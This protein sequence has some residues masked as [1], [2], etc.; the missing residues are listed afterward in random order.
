MSR[1]M[2]CLKLCYFRHRVY[3][4]LVVE[5]VR[6]V[7]SIIIK[8]TIIAA[9]CLKISQPVSATRTPF[10]GMFAGDSKEHDACVVARAG[11]GRTLPTCLV[12]LLRVRT[13]ET[14]QK[15]PCQHIFCPYTSLRTRNPHYTTACFTTTEAIGIHMEGTGM[16]NKIE[17]RLSTSVIA[18]T[19]E[20]WFIAG[21]KIPEVYKYNDC[22]EIRFALQI[23][24]ISA[25]TSI[26]V[27]LCSCVHEQKFQFSPSLKDTR[28]TLRSYHRRATLA[29]YLQ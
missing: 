14:Q 1:K 20:A 13:E 15:S 16:G 29:S 25:N 10:K 2:K 5:N 28:L 7:L 23:R 22:M 21:T 6:A 27:V 19:P 8:S 12:S 17:C 11:S 26:V 9:R 4:P 18:G 24:E 3:W